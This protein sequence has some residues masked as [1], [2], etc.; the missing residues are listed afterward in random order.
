MQKAERVTDPYTHA[1][2]AQRC[3]EAARAGVPLV[4]FVQARLGG[5]SYCGYIKD[6]WTTGDGV[7]MWKLGLLSPQRGQ[8][9]T[10]V[11]NVRQCSGLDGHCHCAAEQPQA[12]GAAAGRSAA[13]SSLPDG[14]HG[15]YIS[16]VTA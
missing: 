8:C 15:E 2:H 16:G 1:A 10:K 13:V 9:H 14:N 11:L 4:Q 3:G 7:D 12:G 6:A 5:T